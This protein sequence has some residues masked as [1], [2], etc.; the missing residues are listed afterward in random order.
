MFWHPTMD[1]LSRMVDGMLEPNLQMGLERHIGA[2]AVC[3][4][5]RAAL[6]HVKT[7]LRSLP[8]L[9]ESFAK[10]PSAP[11][12]VPEEKF[13]FPWKP[14][15]AGTLL[16]VGIMAVVVFRPISPVL[17]VISGSP[18]VV[19][20]EG[21]AGNQIR[22]E[23]SVRNL[24]GSPV[25]LEVPNQIFLRLKPGTTIT[26]QQVD[27]LW[28]NRQPHIVVNL[29]RGEILARTQEGFWGSRLDLLTPSANA[30]V[31]GT[32]FSVKVDPSQDSTVLKVL[33]GS[34]FFTPHLGGVGIDVGAGQTSRIK[35]ERLPSLPKALSPADEGALLET[36]RIGQGPLAAVVVG[37]GPERV[38]DLLRPALLYLSVLD[39]PQIQPFLRKAVREL[40]TALLESDPINQKST[41]KILEMALESMTD[42]EV[43]VPFLLYA[44][45]YAARIGQPLKAQGYFHRVIKEFPQH[46]L[47]P[48]ALAA[49]GIVAETQL[50]SPDA[51]MEN[52]QK[53]LSRYP[54]S[55]DAAYIRELL[56]NRT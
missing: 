35:S 43:A 11:V 9:E 12:L 5:K 26:W 14:V 30:I 3:K 19:A 38:E 24:V 40:N 42:Q 25:D 2:C 28:F 1:L 44:G 17:R 18:E 50:K 45:A 49:S 15:V 29:L 46:S 37:G 21:P 39:H 13:R 55:P 56:K 34:V 32:A 27:R 6:A 41:L 20:S 53:L 48:L 31:K 16:G 54:R 22:P 23:S 51:A 47:A 4:K 33:A 7:T 8:A 52:Y 36:Y 10:E